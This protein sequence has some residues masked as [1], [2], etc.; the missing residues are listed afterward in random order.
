MNVKKKLLVTGGSGTLGSSIIKLA[1]ES[2][3]YEVRTISTDP[4]K[5]NFPTDCT[6]FKSNLATGEGL[7]NALL[8]VDFVIHCASSASDT[9]QVDYEGTAN[10]LKALD[11]EAIENLIYVSIVGI[12]DS[13]FL[14]IWLSYKS[15]S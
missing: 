14:I 12:D 13:T 4:E 2:G 11:E 6:V 1:I 5:H 9:R 7:K 8:G 10:L 15:S 3:R